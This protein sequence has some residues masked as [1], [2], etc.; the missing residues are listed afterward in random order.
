[1]KVKVCGMRNL[2]NIA[3]LIQVQ[4][5]FIGFIF[6]EKS[7]RNVVEKSEIDLPNSIKKV[8]VFVD[9][10]IAFIHVKIKDFKLDYVQLHGNETSYFCKKLKVYFKEKEL[11]TKI[12]K[13]FNI[14]KEFNFSRL[15]EY[16]SFCEFF[17]FDAFGKKAGGNGIIFNW[18]LLQNYQGKIPFL[19]S[20]GID[21]TMT[22]KIKKIKHPKFMGVDINSGFEIEPALKDIKRIKLFS[23]EIRS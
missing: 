17:L 19:L 8:G 11:K 21:E 5:N 20:G 4:P 2:N 1:M 15:K 13:A 9:K 18:E 16:E 7:P 23:D 22:Q 3:K 12:I 14:R 10:E 6:H